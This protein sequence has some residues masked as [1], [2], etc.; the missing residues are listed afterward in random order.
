MQQLLKR[1]KALEEKQKPSVHSTKKSI[2][3]YAFRQLVDFN[4]HRALEI[5]ESLKNV[6]LQVKDKKAVYYAS[7][8]TML[9]VRIPKPIEQFKNYVISLLGDRDYEKIVEA[10]NKVDKSCT[11]ENVWRSP[12]LRLAVSSPSPPITV[13]PFLILLFTIQELRTHPL[14]F[15]ICSLL[16]LISLSIPLGVPPGNLKSGGATRRN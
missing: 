8:H 7:V 10:V 16:F 5:A 15:I 1:L 11:Q 12:F 2:V 13:M 6:A 3:Q 9:Q 4:K 14:N